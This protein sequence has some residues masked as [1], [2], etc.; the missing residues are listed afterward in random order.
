MDDVS[1]QDNVI[2]T[3]KSS[4]LSG[5]LP[6]LLFYGPPGTGK[7]ST[8]LA[9]CRELYGPD[10]RKSGRVLELNASDERGISVIRNK[11]K[12]FAQ[13]TVGKN[14]SRF[15]KVPFKIIILDEADSMTMDAQSALRRMI[16]TYTKVTRFCLVCNYVSRIIEPVASRC[17]KFRFKPLTLDSMLSRLEYITSCEGIR[18]SHPPTAVLETA[19][20]LSEG[21]M[22]KAI[23]VLQSTR[24][25]VGNNNQEAPLTSALLL[26]IAG[27]PPTDFLS[28]LWKALE[29][30]NGKFLQHELEALLATGYA[31][32]VIL[33]Q[34]F[35]D[36][37]DHGTMTDVQK[38]VIGLRIA[39]TDKK[40]LDGASEYLQ[41][42]DIGCLIMRTMGNFTLCYPI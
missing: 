21:D 3:L 14:N 11:V 27:T 26:E 38:G 40:L 33:H 42:M 20:R 32:L 41:L 6:H 23:N 31:G 18:L 19:I 35:Q 29:S 2:K 15:S 22:R 24:Q 34:L 39:Q 37:I 16:E 10:F 9:T 25:L 13:G 17:A 12:S 7:T 1:H 8:I 30:K 28:P 36:V 5:N 4:I